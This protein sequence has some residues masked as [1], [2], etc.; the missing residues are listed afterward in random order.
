MCDYIKQQTDWLYGNQ[1]QIED[2]GLIVSIEEIYYDDYV[3]DLETDNSMFNCG[4]G[5]I[6]VHN[7]DSIFFVP[8]FEESDKK[9]D[10]TLIQKSI[11]IGE[12]AGKEITDG[13]K[14]L[15]PFSIHNL[16]YEKVMY[17]LILMDK[18][19]YTGLLYEYLHDIPDSFEN[20]CALQEYLK[21]QCDKKSMGDASK[22]RGYAPITKSCYG[23]TIDILLYKKDQEM[24]IDFIKNFLI[25]ICSGK[26]DIKEFIITKNLKPRR[27]YKRPDS[28]AHRVLA[29]RVAE[30]DIGKAFQGNERIP[31]VFINVD[32]GLKYKKKVGDNI[33]LPDYVEENKIT[34]DFNYYIEKQIK[35]PICKV[36][37][38]LTDKSENIFD[39][40][41]DENLNENKKKW[42]KY[43]QKKNKEKKREFFGKFFNVRSDP[44]SLQLTSLD[45]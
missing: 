4:V 15:V 3:Y 21:T 25:N 23:K 45:L 42:R 35:N 29:D 20:D 17:P 28:I 41:I 33:E 6:V 24:A 40:I 7:T 14:E 2:G 26:Y 8:N 32:R 30:R 22:K 10:L 12:Q 44:T 13:I 19:L 11:K 1:W 27:S 34:I 43:D 9:N 16:C 39:T 31:Y 38:L 5:N 18:K 37:N 36:L